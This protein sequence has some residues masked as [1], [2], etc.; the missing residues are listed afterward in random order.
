MALAG[1]VFAVVAGVLTWKTPDLHYLAGAFTAV[2]WRWVA[3]AVGFNLVSIAVRALAWHIVLN[4]AL[5]HGARPRHRHVFAAFCVGLLGNAVIPGRVGE[6]ARIAVVSRHLPDRS[7]DWA[8]TVGSVFAH[9]MFDVLPTLG[10]VLYV[11]VSA[12]IPGWA[13]HG[14]ETIVLL[15]ALALAACCAIAWRHRRRQ[16]AAPARAGRFR[17]LLYQA[18][19]GLRVF[20]SPGPAVAVALL[21]VAAWALQLLA[22]YFAFRAFQIDEPIAA[23]AVVLLAINVAIAFPLW[24]GS[25]GLFQAA[26][27]LA[28]L[29]YGVAYEHGFA[30]GIGLQAIEMSV[31][32]GLGLV[33]L[34]REG[35]SFAMLKTIPKV[36]ETI[37]PEPEP[38]PAPR[39]DVRI[40]RRVRRVRPAWARVRAQAS[41]RVG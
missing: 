23:A 39:V 18:L 13:L 9:R 17:R 30:Y 25:V 28:L 21:Q 37:A 32:L 3:V 33:F 16:F 41:E 15:G 10:L 11:V 7:R 35:I 38:E 36:T 4:E 20:H 26:A 24:P 1:A 40:M 14:V 34:A 29:G 27:A 8:S 22:V 5:P 19:A 2:L 31:G 12:R 6:V